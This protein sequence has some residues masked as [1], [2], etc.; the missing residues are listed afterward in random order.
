MCT[1]SFVYY[2]ETRQLDTSKSKTWNEYK[3]MRFDCS[4]LENFVSSWIRINHHL[5]YGFEDTLINTTYTTTN[6]E[7]ARE[8]GG[9]LS[10]PEEE[11]QAAKFS[12]SNAFST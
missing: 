5:P 8:E 1:H 3:D 4:L 9:I 12:S 10:L 2:R 6:N 7:V 11:L